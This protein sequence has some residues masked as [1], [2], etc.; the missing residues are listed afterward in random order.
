MGDGNDVD[1]LLIQ[2]FNAA[3]AAA[4]EG[5]HQQALRSYRRLIVRAEREGLAASEEFLTT[6]RMRAGFCLMDLGRYED[7]RSELEVARRHADALDRLG[8]YE[9][10]FAYGN[11]LGSLGLL[12]ESFGAL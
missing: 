8:R 10:A 6:A 3:A 11:T 7:A 4:R 5:R 9:L 2:A 1:D 12:K